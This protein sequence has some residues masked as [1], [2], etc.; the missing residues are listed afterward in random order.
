MPKTTFTVGS[1][2][3]GEFLRSSEPIYEVPKFQ[4]RYSWSRSGGEWETLW[5][6]LMTARASQDPEYFLGTVVVSGHGRPY[7]IIDGQQR[8]ATV[9]AMFS[10]IRDHLYKIGDEATAASIQDKLIVRSDYRGKQTTILKLGLADQ[11]E[12]RRYIQLQPNDADRFPLYSRPQKVGPGRP[13]TNLVRAV[14]DY[15]YDE[16]GKSIQHLPN[17]AAKREKLIDLQEFLEKRITVIRIEVESDV[18]AYTIFETLNDRGLDLSVADLLKNHLLS[19]AKSDQEAT[20]LFAAWESLLKTLEDESIS[21]FLRH[22]WMSRNGVI[23]E[24]QLYRE[25]KK[26]IEENKRPP[27]SVL[28]QLLEDADTYARLL[29]PILGDPCAWE[30]MSLSEM[31]LRQ[32]LPFLMAAKATGKS[33]K[34]FEKAVRLVEAVTARYTLVAD[35]NPNQ[36]ERAYAEWATRLRASG[37]SAFQAIREEA[38][39]MCPSDDEFSQSFVSLQDLKP[40][41]ARYLLRKLAQYRGTKEPVP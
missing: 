27:V 6:D 16:I 26:D 1:F 36:L 5:E 37:F 14:L 19:M 21:S 28:T 15:Y 12:F 3:I 30:L 8:L 17:E 23:T 2:P 25:I 22:Q 13:R 31:R 41:Q 34:D 33:E 24:R 35:R 9:T 20:D 40:P 11:E 32:G 4:R 29:S 18:I 10:A 38:A 39:K 7:T